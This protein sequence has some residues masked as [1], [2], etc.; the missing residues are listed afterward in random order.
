MKTDA[1]KRACTETLVLTLLK[2][3]PL[4]G[5]EMAKEVERR[6]EGY[7]VFTHSTLYPVLH[8]LEKRGLISGEW[9]T[10]EEGE[11]PRKYYALTPKGR[12]AH[13]RDTEALQRFFRMI[14]TLIPEV[15]T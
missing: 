1:L 7:V 9:S 8:R 4:H 5:Y 12:G 6:S 14:S 10:G 15:A 2:E 11:R 13:G 3:G